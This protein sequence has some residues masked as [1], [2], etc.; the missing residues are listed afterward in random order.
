MNE[1][2][3]YQRPLT[4][5]EVNARKKRNTA[6]AIILIAFMLLIFGISVV[7]L[8]GGIARPQDWQE[9]TAGWQLDEAPVEAGEGPPPGMEPAEE[10]SS[11]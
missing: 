4:A 8:Q 10:T 3:Q 1:F 7:K 9:E 6:L 5:A 2:N 11:E